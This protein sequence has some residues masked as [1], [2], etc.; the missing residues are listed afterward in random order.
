MVTT[1]Q[2]HRKFHLT[3]FDLLYLDE[4]K[5]R[6]FIV[7]CFSHSHRET[8]ERARKIICSPTDSKSIENSV[9]LVVRLA[10]KKAGY[11]FDNPTKDGLISVLDNLA[12]EARLMG[13]PDCIVDYH[14]NEIMK[15]V[16]RL[17]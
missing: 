8:F 4:I 5:V 9:I 13:T 12:K 16:N 10:F 11:D 14:K 6:D 15:A 2:E 1:G 7:K 17:K 3:K